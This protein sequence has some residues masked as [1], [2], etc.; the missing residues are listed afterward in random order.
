MKR[1]LLVGPEDCFVLFRSVE[2]DLKTSYQVESI[3]LNHSV[4]LD[5]RLQKYPPAE[6]HV[7]VL[8]DDRFSNFVRT[9]LSTTL[10]EKGYRAISYKSPDASVGADVHISENCIVLGHVIL[11]DGVTIDANCF[12]GTGCSVGVRTQIGE[13]STL[14]SHCRVGRGVTI[15]SRVIIGTNVLIES[16][17][18]I[19]NECEISVPG[20][21]RGLIE[22]KTYF[23]PKVGSS[24]RIYQFH[25]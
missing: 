9:S 7:L 2:T 25:N 6:F 20:N 16:A 14:H 18:V 24:A 10:K 22:Q 1:L 3:R 15:G 12:L 23:H 21:Y 4:N 19:G 8:C 17:A 5:E 13:S 11:E